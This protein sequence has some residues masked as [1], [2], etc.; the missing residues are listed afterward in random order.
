MRL[1]RLLR[2]APLARF[3]FSTQGLK[4]SALFALLVALSAGEAFESLEPH[5]SFWEGVYGAVTTMTTVGYGDPPVT[6]NSAK[7]VAVV[8]MIVGIGFFAVITGAVADR[9]LTART[10]ALVEAAEE[11]AETEHDL[12]VQ[13]RDIGQRLRHLEATLER[14]SLAAQ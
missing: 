2:L 12:L 14:R 1:L 7:V 9:F 8:V 4:Y 3:I 11:T 5:R 13:V 10:K 6:T